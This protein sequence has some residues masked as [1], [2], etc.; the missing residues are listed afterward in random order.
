MYDRAG[1]S[2]KCTLIKTGFKNLRAGTEAKFRPFVDAL[3]L[4][5]TKIF[6]FYTKVE[7]LVNI[8]LLFIF[9]SHDFRSAG[10]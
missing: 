5:N 7:T 10:S 3:A 6:C 8:Y 4:C 1:L 9:S 2:T